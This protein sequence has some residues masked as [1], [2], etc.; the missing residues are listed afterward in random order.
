VGT[1]PEL[2]TSVS[3]GEIGADKFLSVP[4]IFRDYKVGR[5]KKL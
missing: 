2:H 5:L 3:T 4:Y 1:V